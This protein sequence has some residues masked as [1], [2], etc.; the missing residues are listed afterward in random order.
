M[1]F[2]YRYVAP[3][4][5][6]RKEISSIRRQYEG[7]TQEESK[8]SRLRRLDARVK[9]T[10]NGVS[11]SAGIVFCLVFGTGMSAILVWESLLVGVLLSAVG[12]AGMIAAYPAYKWLYRR[13]KKKYGEEILRLSE[14]LL[15]G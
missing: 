12:T 7:G 6:E 1:K 2:E 11:L 8:L 14:E 9:N 15:N 3:T 4:E 13:G 5:E 10:A